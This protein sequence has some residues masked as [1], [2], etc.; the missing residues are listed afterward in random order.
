MVRLCT[1]QP[2]NHSFKNLT[3]LA[4][5]QLTRLDKPIGIYLLMWPTLWALEVASPFLTD[6]KIVGIFMAGVVL[7]RSAGCALNDWADRYFDGSVKRTKNRPLVTGSLKPHHALITVVILVAMALWLVLQLNTKTVQLAIVAAALTALYPFT[8]R[9]LPYPQLFLALAFSCSIL[10]AFTAY[11]NAIPIDAWLLFALNMLWVIAYDTIYAMIDKEHDLKIGIKSTAIWFG[12][13]CIRNIIILQCLFST[14]SVLFGLW[15]GY[16][17]VFYIFCLVNA[18]LFIQQYL[19]IQ[20]N[21][22]DSLLSAFRHNH[23]VGASFFTA[24]LFG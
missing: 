11:H 13:H 18:L 17:I 15:K 21:T 1:A 24:L 22:D 12:K 4:L 14:G 2:T 6:W 23:W 8:K 19:F 20:R 16:S 9:W 3:M 10:M 7:M 5:I